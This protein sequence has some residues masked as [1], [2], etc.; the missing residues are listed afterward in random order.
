MIMEYV[1]NNCALWRIETIGDVKRQKQ[2]PR[3]VLKLV[4][5]VFFKLNGFSNLSH[6]SVVPNNKLN[7][8]KRFL[9]R[10]SYF[11]FPLLKWKLV[12]LANEIGNY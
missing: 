8:P 7:N 6:F 9:F 4:L 11:N 10:L 12:F 5:E 1:N 3:G 2:P